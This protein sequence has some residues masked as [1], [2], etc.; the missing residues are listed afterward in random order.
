APALDP[1]TVRAQVAG[2]SADAAR[3]AL[4]RYGSVDLQLWPGWVTAVPSLEWR[5]DVV[6]DPVRAR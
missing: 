3:S 6:I 4:A 1:A 2:L 5:I